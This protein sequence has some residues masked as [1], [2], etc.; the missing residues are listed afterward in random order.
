MLAIPTEVPI[1]LTEEDILISLF[2]EDKAI[3]VLSKK[4]KATVYLLSF[5]LLIF[6]S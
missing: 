6:L 2:V 3:K 1:R 5:S 4:S